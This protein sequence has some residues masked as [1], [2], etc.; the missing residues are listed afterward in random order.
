MN[1]VFHSIKNKSNMADACNSVPLPQQDI[2][3]PTFYQLSCKRPINP[4]MRSIIDRH[5]KFIESENWPRK[6]FAADP[7]L[8]AD[9]GFYYLVDGDRTKCW[10]CN[11]GLKNWEWFDD[12]WIKHAKWFPLREFLLK[13]R[14]VHFVKDIVKGFVSLN[15]PPDPNPP[16][17]SKLQ[18]LE[19]LVNY[20][21]LAKRQPPFPPLIDPRGNVDV[22]EKVEREM[23]LGRNVEMAKLLG[24]EDRKISRV[25]TKR[26]QEHN[27][28]FATFYD[29]MLKLMEQPDG[30]FKP[31]LTMKHAKEI[32]DEAECLKCEKEERCM[33][34]LPCAHITHC[35]SC[36]RKSQLCTIC[37]E[38]VKEK[39]RS[40]R[41][42]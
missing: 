12:P 5:Q 29:F 16:P 17:K 22:K 2:P 33:V 34:Y 1:S 42:Q 4:H 24:F 41:V 20:P 19:K 6:R 26:F 30:I 25:L 37:G 18:Y 31:K 9:A 35:F 28:N 40:Y 39:I 36:S 23:L 14:G 7:K 3:P 13:N 38:F 15:R 32:L 10:Y 11:G 27:K 21:T 8:I